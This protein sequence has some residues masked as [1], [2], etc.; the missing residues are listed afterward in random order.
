MKITAKCPECGAVFALPE[1]L[2]EWQALFEN[3]DRCTVTDVICPVCGISETVQA[4]NAETQKLFRRQIEYLSRGTKKSAK[5]AQ[6]TEILLNHSR[7]KLMERL[8]LLSLR[9]A[10]VKE[11]IHFELKAESED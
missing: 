11:P 9:S 3:G 5:K 4:D 10:D 1:G 7:S 8:N 2:K 6:K